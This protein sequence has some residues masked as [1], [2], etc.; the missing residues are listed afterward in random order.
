MFQE[1]DLLFAREATEN[2]IPVRVT[3]EAV[4][5]DLML[6]FKLIVALWGLL[7]IQPFGDGMNLSGLAVYIG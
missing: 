2:C 4:D 7:A 5:D 6:E 1:F 3:S